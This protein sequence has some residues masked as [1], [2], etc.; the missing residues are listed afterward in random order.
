MIT[1]ACNRTTIAVAFLSRGAILHTELFQYEN[2][3]WFMTKSSGPDLVAG[4]IDV[5]CVRYTNLVAIALWVKNCLVCA[6]S[7]IEH[8]G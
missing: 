7:A 1:D 8:D 5:K 2:A 3:A 4:L 6:S